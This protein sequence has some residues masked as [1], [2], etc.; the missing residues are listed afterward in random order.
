VLLLAAIGVN[1]L[2]AN[3]LQTSLYALGA[4]VYPTAV[5]A[6]GLATS[7][8][9]GRLGA[10]LSSLGGAAIIKA[11]GSAWWNLMAFAMICALAG[12]FMIRNHYPAPGTE[13]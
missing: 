3:A 1:G 11:G 10:L 8:A 13:K 7:S 9:V 4:H 6:S 2:F 5:R 12:V